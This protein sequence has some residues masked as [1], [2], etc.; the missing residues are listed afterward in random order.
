LIDKGFQN[1]PPCASGLFEAAWRRRPD[2]LFL[3]ADENFAGT[4]CVGVMI[5]LNPAPR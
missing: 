1:E 2:N 4:A 5:A 3:T